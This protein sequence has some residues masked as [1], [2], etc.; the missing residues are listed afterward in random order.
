MGALLGTQATAGLNAAEIGL[1]WGQTIVAGTYEVGAPDL[2]NNPV[3][4]ETIDRAYALADTPTTNAQFAAGL[5]QLEGRTTVL[6][7]TLPK[8]RWA[9][10]ARGTEEEIR[11]IDMKR[12]TE[13]VVS[14][15]PQQPSFIKVGDYFAS[16]ALRAFDL[17]APINRH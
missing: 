4:N 5:R 12:L 1:A 3:R 8:N 15:V 14:L 7:T 11:E 10:L 16:G 6:M 13:I 17:I 2:E 9:I